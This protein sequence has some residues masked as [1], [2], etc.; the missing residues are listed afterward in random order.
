MILIDFEKAFDSISWDLYH[1]LEHFGF[2]PSFINWIKLFNSNIKGT[3][4]QVGFLSEFINIQRGCKQGDPIAPYLF[5]LCAQIILK[6]MKNN[7]N[8]N[9]IHVGAEEYKISK[10]CL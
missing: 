7:N 1:V 2:G 4:L 10:L 6:M 8:I 3:V 9:G 5:I